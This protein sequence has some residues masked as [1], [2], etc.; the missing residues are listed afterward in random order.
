MIRLF[1]TCLSMPSKH[2]TPPYTS[3]FSVTLY[4]DDSSSKS[5]AME[6]QDCAWKFCRTEGSVQ[7]ETFS[8][9]HQQDSRS[10]YCR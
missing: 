8:Q 2:F 1:H 4:C 7:L 10:Q 9:S 5:I 3:T 6:P